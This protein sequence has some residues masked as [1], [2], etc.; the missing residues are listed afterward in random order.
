MG[1]GQALS[2]TFERGAALARPVSC[3]DLT[4]SWDNMGVDQEI[5]EDEGLPAG[6]NCLILDAQ[7]FQTGEV[8]FF[9]LE[10]FDVGFAGQAYELE[11]TWP[12]N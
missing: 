10:V 1:F 2:I 8:Y 6:S 7:N 3:T 11:V 5:Y 12:P 9:E 4:V